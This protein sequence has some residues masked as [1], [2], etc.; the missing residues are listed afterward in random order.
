M[1]SKNEFFNLNIDITNIDTG[2]YEKSIIK[3]INRNTAIL[4]SYNLSVQMGEIQK[5]SELIDIYN[6][7]DTVTIKIIK[8][9]LVN[10]FN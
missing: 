9:E 7:F 1:I 4:D 2:K 6:T 5:I 10:D 8:S 3:K